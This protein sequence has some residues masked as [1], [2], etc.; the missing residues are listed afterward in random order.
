M[1]IVTLVVGHPIGPVSSSADHTALVCKGSSFHPYPIQALQVA[2]TTRTPLVEHIL[3]LQPDN[4]HVTLQVTSIYGRIH[5]FPCLP[6][7]IRRTNAY[8]L[9]TIGVATEP[10]WSQTVWLYGDHSYQN[11][12]K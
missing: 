6:D 7:F 1:L 11:K 10:W 2:Q 4:T 12:T 8:C 5:N 3:Q 9:G